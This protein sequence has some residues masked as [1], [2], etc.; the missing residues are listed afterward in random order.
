MS[1]YDVKILPVV[2]DGTV[3]ILCGPAHPVAYL[4][5]EG[6]EWLAIP[7]C[8][9]LKAPFAVLFDDGSIFDRYLFGMG[10]NGGW[11]RM[12]YRPRIRVQMGHTVQ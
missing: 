5:R 7:G 1:P 11:R 2:D 4:E 9:Q 10:I 6:G 8:R 3:G 12:H